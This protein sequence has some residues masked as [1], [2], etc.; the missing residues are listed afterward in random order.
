MASDKII[1]TRLYFTNLVCGII[2]GSTT[3][4]LTLLVSWKGLS[5]ANL[6]LII[7]ISFLGSAVQPIVGAISDNL[8]HKKYLV[9]FF[10]GVLFSSSLL[11]FF[12][13]SLVLIKVAVFF[14][15]ISAQSS[16]VILDGLVAIKC[17]EHNYNYGFIRSGLSLGFGL[18]IVASLPFIY[19]FDISAMVV[20]VAILG[21]LLIV[22]ALRMHDSS[23]GK[24]D[25]H[26]ITEVKEMFKNK[27]FIVVM[28]VAVILFSTNAIKLNYQTIKLEN[29]DTKY[30]I[31]AITSFIMIIPEIVLLPKYDK[32]F[33]KW[34]FNKTTIIAIIIF[35]INLLVL[36]FSKTALPILIFAPLHGL[37]SAI[38]IPRITMAFRSLLSAG[39]ISTGMILRNTVSAILNF[40]LSSFLIKKLFVTVSIEAVFYT[41]I[42]LFIIN[43]LVLVLL[44]RVNKFRKLYF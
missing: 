5:D 14:M 13:S 6:A 22:F 38:Y 36:A 24:T 41:L 37:G 29:L 35:I 21:I 33:S 30:I 42:I 8:K 4:G 17:G 7:G 31:I 3:M 15:S 44:N 12:T 11:L 1:Q 2:L 32:Y 25:V 10:G 40:L 28:F 18:S 43:L 27:V 19:I 20:F 9:A 16:F 26:Y 39:I 23:I 34:S